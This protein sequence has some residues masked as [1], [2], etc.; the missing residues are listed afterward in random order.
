MCSFLFL[1][2]W[3]T[4]LHES[5]EGGDGKRNIL[6]GW[7][8]CCRRASHAGFYRRDFLK[9]E[10]RRAELFD[11]GVA[12]VMSKVTHM[13][14]GVH[15]VDTT[16][17]Y[18]LIVGFALAHISCALGTSWFFSFFFHLILDPWSSILDPRSS[19]LDPRFAGNWNKALILFF[20]TNVQSQ[21]SFICFKIGSYLLYT[22]EPAISE[23][24]KCQAYTW[25]AAYGK[26]SL[27]RA[28]TITTSKFSVISIIMVTA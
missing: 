11:Y 18:V 1:S 6:L 4:H 27:T 14:H 20:I 15:S 13:L 16:N 26:W 9:T 23:H 21:N 22:V 8:Y 17:V 2:N 5:R 12:T 19:I 7:L 3:P 25:V 10:K 28:D 24:S